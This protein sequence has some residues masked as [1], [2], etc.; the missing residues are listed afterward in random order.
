MSYT[1]FN[2]TTRT[3]RKARRCDWCWQGIAVGERYVNS[4]GVWEG[5]F[6]NHHMHPE[7]HADMQD[8][9]RE[10]WG[11]CEFTPGANERPVIAAAAKPSGEEQL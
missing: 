4:T 11:V 7:C 2:T 5:D 3:A 10:N 6:Q 8:N 1:H 9:A